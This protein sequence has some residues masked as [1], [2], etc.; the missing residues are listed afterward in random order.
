ML[1]VMS[2][3]GR[4][5]SGV[6]GRPV[7]RLLQVRASGGHRIIIIEIGV[8]A[9]VGDSGCGGRGR[10]RMMV[11]HH[12][13]VLRGLLGLRWR[14]RPVVGVGGRMM[15]IRVQRGDG[16]RGLL[17]VLAD[18]GCGGRMVMVMVKFARHRLAAECEARVGSHE[19]VRLV[20]VG[21]CGR[22]TIVHHGGGGGG[23]GGHRR[24]LIELGEAV[25]VEFV[26]VA[27]AVH[28]RHDILVVVV[29]ESARQLVVV[30][31]GLAL[32]LAPLALHL[33]RVDEL[34]FAVGALPADYGRVGRV[35]QELEQELPQLDLAGARLAEARRRVGEQVVG[36]L[37]ACDVRAECQ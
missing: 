5:H 12:V 14:R 13:M 36:V 32:A 16:R 35:R 26:G 3:S 31:V 23:G 34:E 6:S 30:H 29:A 37:H 9:R 25:K 4:G 19:Q 18:G 33:V 1:M 10:R 2:V 17:L 21:D 20:F 15:M 28:F 8:V 7:A 22:R 11:M 27:F 24:R